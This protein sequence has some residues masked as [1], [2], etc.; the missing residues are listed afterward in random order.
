MRDYNFEGRPFPDKEQRNNA[1]K[2]SYEDQRNLRSADKKDAL[3]RLIKKDYSR[4]NDEQIDAIN[5]CFDYKIPPNYII[6]YI[7]IGA[8]FIKKYALDRII[9]S[10]GK[11]VSV[12][13]YEKLKNDIDAKEWM[14]RKKRKYNFEGR[15]FPDKEQLKDKKNDYWKVYYED[16]FDAQNRIEDEDYSRFSEKQIRVIKLCVNYNLHPGYIVNYINYYLNFITKKDL[17]YFIGSK[18]KDVVE[19]DYIN[20]A[21]HVNLKSWRYKKKKYN[22]EGRPF[23]DKEQRFN[24][25][26]DYYDIISDDESDATERLIKKDYSRFNEDQIKAIELCLEYNIPYGYITGYIEEYPDE[27]TRERL[28]YYIGSKGKDVSD[29]DYLALSYYLSTC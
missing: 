19:T 11:D 13:D 2:D 5:L 18:G 28:D 7:D 1:V 23:P 17:D 8:S 20:F 27:V 24:R 3:E 21:T 6:D 15:P 22:F 4:F 16:K 26:N 29:Y 10:K 9:G 12:E 14:S 25:D